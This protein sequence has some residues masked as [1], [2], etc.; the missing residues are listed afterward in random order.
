MR[1]TALTLTVSTLVLSVFGAFLH[2]LQ[3]MNAF[4]KDTGFSI[5]GAGTTVVFL[6]YSVLAVALFCVVTILWLGRFERGTDAASALHCETVIPFVA[7]WVLCAVFAA[8]SF[9]QLFTAARSDFPLWQR[10]FGAFGILA[11]VSFPFLFGRKGGSGAGGVGRGASV[12]IT[13]FSCYWMVFTYKMESQDPIIWNYALE[14][15]AVAAATVA[16]YEVAAFFFGK[17]HVRRTLIAAALGIYFCVTALF[18]ARSTVIN[19]ML[20]VTAALLLV[21][22]FLLI[23]NMSEKHDEA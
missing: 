22:E 8:A 6:I 13:L 20:G 18:E 3:T 1:R 21:L 14:I 9:Y 10:L 5:P 12:L 7:G 17:G 4:E 15:L 2:W 16:F 23:A 19:V 11:A